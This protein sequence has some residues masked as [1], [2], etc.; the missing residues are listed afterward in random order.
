MCT[1]SDHAYVNTVGYRLFKSSRRRPGLEILAHATLA[2][3]ALWTATAVLAEK[4]Y[5]V[6][7][8]DTLSS[9]AKKHDTS[10]TELARVN[11]LRDIHN[12][13]IGQEL[14]LPLPKSVAKV[15]V[16]KKGDMLSDIAR[17]HNLSVHAIV[18]FNKLPSADKLSI[19]DEILIPA[20]PG[21]SISPPL[22]S[23]P[24]RHS[25]NRIRVR[26]RRWKN[27]VIHHSG[28]DRGTLRG[29]DRY[30]RVERRMENGL[31][32]HFVIGNGKGISDGKIETGT[33]WKRQLN[34]GHLA[35]TRL[36]SNSIGICLVGNF[37]QS[38]PTQK[39]I[40]SLQALC[41]YLSRMCSIGESRIQSHRQINPRP[42]KCPGK[43]FPMNRF[44][45]DFRA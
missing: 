7:K 1:D 16:V 22:L 39:Q 26:P 33:R 24:V 31:A 23:S 32:Y 30:H 19:G 6:R 3:L 42:T 18:E 9:I 8:R 15:H 28:A 13:Q 29:M 36:N 4:T 25:L 43:Y 21:Q 37:E 41:T 10:A 17:K 20:E 35:S 2:I 5:T 40:E 38:R 27:I 14:V 12:L 34:G 45:S 44:K 11:E